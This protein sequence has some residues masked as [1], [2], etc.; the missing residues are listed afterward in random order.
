M[1]ITRFMALAEKA[2]ILTIVLEDEA[3]D[4]W[5]SEANWE[6]VE[7]DPDIVYDILTEIDS[8]GYI[9]LGDFED[10]VELLKENPLIGEITSE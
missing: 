3:A 1:N 2:S 5:R 4:C 9:V 10:L 8:E 6:P 7:A